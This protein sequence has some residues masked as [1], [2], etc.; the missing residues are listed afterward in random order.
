MCKQRFQCWDGNKG[1]RCWVIRT[2][3]ADKVTVH[4]LYYPDLRK[5]VIFPQRS[6]T[7]PKSQM[8]FSF[9][10]SPRLFQL[11]Y[12]RDDCTFR[13]QILPDGYNV[14]VSDRHH[15][16]LSLGNHRQ[17]LQGRDRGVPALAQ[18]LPRISTVDQAS[19]FGLDVPEQAGRSAAQTGEPADVMDSFG[20]LS[21]MIH[22]PSFH[23]R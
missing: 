22:S 1:S 14:Y 15:V 9:P 10:P 8:F 12:S 4:L 16:L 23:K 11:S 3:R 18:F 20:K 7:D 5:G 6:K 13:E 21:Q 19:A 17:R 2:S